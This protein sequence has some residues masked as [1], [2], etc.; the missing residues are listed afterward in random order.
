MQ[1]GDL[2]KLKEII[3]QRLAKLTSSKLNIQDAL[4]E[5]FVAGGCFPPVNAVCGGL[6]ANE[7]LKAVSKKGIPANN[8]IFYD[9]VSG[10]A[11]TQ[12]HG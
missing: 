11:V 4:I 7:M 6:L 8:C 1:A 9:L 5:E 3:K 2:A 10:A 12:R